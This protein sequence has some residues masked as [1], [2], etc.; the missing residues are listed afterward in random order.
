MYKW[1]TISVAG[2]VRSLIVTASDLHYCPEV[3]HQHSHTLV[4]VAYLSV[5]G[6][7]NSTIVKSLQIQNP[8]ACSRI[9]DFPATWKWQQSFCLWH[10]AHMHVHVF[11]CT[12]SKSICRSSPA[13]RRYLHKSTLFSWAVSLC[14]FPTSKNSSVNFLTVSNVYLTGVVHWNVVK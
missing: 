4:A 10:R 3:E 13:A 8:L 11:G 5:K 1:H 7:S 12:D 6:I 14:E 9:W 2:H